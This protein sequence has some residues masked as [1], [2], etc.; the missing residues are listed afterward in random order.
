MEVLEKAGII[1]DTKARI[2]SGFVEIPVC[3]L[4]IKPKGFKNV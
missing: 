4:L 3:D 1:R 2:P